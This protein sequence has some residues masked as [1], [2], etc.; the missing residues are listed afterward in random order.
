MLGLVNLLLIS[1]SGCLFAKKGEKTHKV[2]LMDLTDSLFLNCRKGT[3]YFVNSIGL[4]NGT[5][6]T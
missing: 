4:N 3:Q 6:K 2:K 5:V 1:S